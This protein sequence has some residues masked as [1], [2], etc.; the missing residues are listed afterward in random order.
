MNN[1]LLG[2]LGLVLFIFC[3]VDL[4]HLKEM[5]KV[6]RK[7]DKTFDA[8]CSVWVEVNKKQLQTKEK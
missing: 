5:L 7:L 3:I 2:F 1:L 8:F 6:L 4:Y